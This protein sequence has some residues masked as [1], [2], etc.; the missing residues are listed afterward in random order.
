MNKYSISFEVARLVQKAFPE[1]A[2]INEIADKILPFLERTLEAHRQPQMLAILQRTWIKLNCGIDDEP[3]SA[4][5]NACW[6]ELCN[7]MGT[8][9]AIRW[10]DEAVPNED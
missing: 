2:D 9:R 1:A 10:A 8:E 3:D 4:V 5:A 6:D 7:V